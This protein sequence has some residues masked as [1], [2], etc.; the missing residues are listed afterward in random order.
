MAVQRPLSLE[1]LTAAWVIADKLSFRLRL[2]K[3]G[4]VGSVIDADDKFAR[5]L[6]HNGKARKFVGVEAP[7]EKPAKPKKEQKHESV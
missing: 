4:Q 1:R 5:E 7:A 3:D 6:I 2:V